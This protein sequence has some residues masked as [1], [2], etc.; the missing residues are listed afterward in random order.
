MPRILK[1]EL[2]CTA[3]RTSLYPQSQY[4]FDERGRIGLLVF[5]QIPGWQHIGDMEW[6][7]R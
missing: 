6:Q 2:A 7:D 1:E 5:T 3:V 4:F